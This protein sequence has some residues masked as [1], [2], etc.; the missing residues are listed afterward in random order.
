[1]HGRVTDPA[2][3]PIAGASIDIW[4]ADSAGLYDV[5][6]PDLDGMRL[7][8]R[9]RTDAEGRYD[10]LTSFPAGYPIPT[11]GPVGKMLTATGRHPMR[12]GH[13]HFIIAAPGYEPLVTHIF[14][15]GDKYLDSDAV[16]AVKHDLVT[17][18][19]PRAAGANGPHYTATYDFSLEP[20]AGARQAAE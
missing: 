16:F 4:Q 19:V 18:F 13:V 11:D 9:F 2:G 8:G 10:F 1:V 3:R 20:V 6:Y 7:R 14:A 15:A 12:P 5:Q 17:A